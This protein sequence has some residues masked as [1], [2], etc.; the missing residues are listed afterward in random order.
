MRYFK[1]LFFMVVSLLGLAAYSQTSPIWGNLKKGKYEVGFKAM[2]EFDY[3]RLYH[4]PH[5]VTGKSFP[6]EAARPVRMFVWYPAVYA[7]DA[8]KMQYKDY[9]N[10]KPENAAFDEFNE[11]LRKYDRRFSVD[12]TNH[13]DSSINKILDMKVEAVKEAKPINRKFP[14]ILHFLGLNDR[15]NENIPLWEYL[16]SNGY[17]VL[18]IPQ[19][20]VFGDVSMELEFNYLPSRE[21]QVRDMEFAMGKLHDFSNIDFS[22]IGVIGYSYGS[23]FA[24][25]MA[26]LNGNIK[27][28]ATFDG[29]V[30]NKN[31]Q[32][33]LSDGFYNSKIKADWLNIYRAKYEPLDLKLFD[34]LKYTKRYKVTYTNANH[35]DF[36][37]FAIACSLMP[38]QVPAYALK[39]RTVATGKKNYETTCALTLNFFD[40][41]L[42]NSDNS[43]NEFDKIIKS[44]KKEG[45][46][47]DYEYLPAR[48]FI[49]AEDLAH[50]IIYYGMEDAEK[51]YQTVKMDTGFDNAITPSSL[52]AYAKALRMG[53]RRLEKSNEVLRFVINHFPTENAAYIEMARN[54]IELE[55]TDEAKKYLDKVLSVDNK[56]K[57]ALL[58]MQLI[59]YYK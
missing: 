59:K 1:C 31:G 45:I 44:R 37:D 8:K 6:G 49:D 47:E 12:W 57:E 25:R 27:A 41:S 53:G 10:V 36:E 28:L 29:N 51:T 5:P 39:E 4:G 11:A 50:I 3:S 24:M 48:K 9:I 33:I 26:M 30:N 19:Y 40:E 42:K 58:L 32:S 16:A 21:S 55:K 14:L 52:I 23:V 38:N 43:K 17:V 15:R 18:T 13:Q 20:T 22:N 35:G 56:N 46:I 7:S 2:Y 34:A 54:D